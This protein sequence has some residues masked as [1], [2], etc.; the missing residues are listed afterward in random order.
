MTLMRLNY[1]LADFENAQSIDTEKL[2]G[3]PIKTVIFVGQTQKSLPIKLVKRLLDHQDRVDIYE[4]AGNEKN[5]LDFQVAF[6]AGR[7][8]ERE[9]GAFIHIV[10]A[11]KGFD[12]LVAYI[13]SQNRSCSRAESFLALPFFREGSL[14]P[15]SEKEDYTT[16]HCHGE[17]SLLWLSL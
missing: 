17:S 9:P 15:V 2:I 3:L 12:P 16:F 1:V 5:A 7:I 4:S 11:D 10:S 8:F 14:K 6:Y 13:K